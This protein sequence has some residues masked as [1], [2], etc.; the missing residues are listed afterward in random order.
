[1]EKS[2]E[3][4]HQLVA[5]FKA[6]EKAYLAPSYSESQVRQDFIDK[7]FTAL[8][9]DVTH[10]VQKNPYEQ[11]VKIENRVSMVGSQRRADYAF[12]VA[13]NYDQ[14]KFF[15]EAKKPSRALANADDYFQTIR[16]AWNTRIPIAVL[17]DFEEFH[18]LDCRYKPNIKTA[19][20]RKIGEFRYTEYPNEETFAKIFHLFGREAVAGGSLEKYAVTLPKK[21]TKHLGAVQLVDDAFLEELDEYR[22][23]LAKAFKKTNEQLQGEELTEAVQRTIDRLVFIRFLE[24]KGIEDKQIISLSDPKTAWK[25]F[26]TLC[27]RFEPKYNGLIFKSHRILDSGECKSPDGHSF[28][29]ICQKISD[30]SSP[31]DFNQIP[32]SILGSIYERFLGKVVHATEKRVKVEEKPEVRKAGGVY[33]TPEYI[34]RYIVKE[35]VGKLLYNDTSTS[36]K[37][38]SHPEQASVTNASKDAS[39]G[40]TPEQIATM[41][42]A[43]I[44]CGSG[45]FL[46]EVYTQVLDYHLQYYLQHPETAGKD[47]LFERDG[48][49]YLTLKKKKEILTNNV[50]GVDID[51]QATEVTQ[52]SL[53]L[54]MLENAT[55]NEAHQFGMF[56]ETILPDLRQN[57]IC[58]NSLIGRDILEGELFSTIDEA[59]LKPMNYGDVF[60]K[61]MKRGGFDVVVGNP[62]YVRI[63]NLQTEIA[64]IDYLKRKYVAAS[65]G[66]FDLYSVFLE[67]ALAFLKHDGKL[68]YIVPHKFFNSNYGRPLRGLLAK[69]N[70]VSKIV[71]FGD[72][73]I[74]MGA[75]T[76]TVLIFLEKRGANIIDV[77][78]VDNIDNWIIGNGNTHGVMNTKE[79][80]SD[81]WSFTV[82]DAGSLLKR[83][84]IYPLKLEN[85][86]SRIFQGLK[87]GADPVFILELHSEK[88]FYSKALD[89]TIEIEPKYLRP[90]FKSGEMKKYTL[91]PN[92]RF[93]IFPYVT[94]KL[95]EW[96]TIQHEAP[97]T[98]KY[99]ESCKSILNKR[100]NGKFKG[101]DWYGFS[102]NQALE[103]ISEIK[104]LT[105]DIN[106]SANYCF[107]NN[108]TACFPGGA[109]GG[110]GIVLPQNLYLYVLGLLN[111]KL[112]DFYLKNIST[113]FR[114]GWF[115]YDARVLKRLP[116]RTI[117]STNETE[118]RKFDNIVKQVEQMLEAKQKLSTAKTDGEVNRLESLCTSL[119]RKINDAV[120]ELYGLTEEE[121]KIVE[122]SN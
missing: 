34:V 122:N 67:R 116:I 58:G 21:G 63:Q 52:L 118:K 82:G 14:I 49:K 10:S 41:A 17:T 100:E 87:T 7:F 121:I 60:P 44:A 117:D 74:F 85:L 95:E 6:N 78:K 70:H 120:Y 62:P 56:K 91:L 42:F 19:L 48:K 83:L 27:K 96:T 24:D 64:Q 76:Y 90:L 26:V 55:M 112:V 29:E 12:S 22:E 37:E 45:S 61:I 20:E 51:F 119:D 39:T 65:A 5:D 89:S 110:Y 103:I 2:L 18:I 13:P 47:V 99:L 11:E 84:D 88:K 77:T 94:G 8:G 102:R 75:T 23:I 54:K 16:Y 32:I 81:T 43:D 111:S 97:K 57:I 80:T 50:Y 93:V 36:A 115:G 30:P 113:N 53:Y 98:A 35:T 46:I 104:I 68:G 107:D 72:I 4:V 25:L 1:M 105:A 101:K 9:W 109:A 108:G 40:K 15:V 92:T 71:H 86:A 79:L 73:Q 33:Y 59:H 3:V 114:G 28:A 69:G 38:K 106:P 66:N 31:Y